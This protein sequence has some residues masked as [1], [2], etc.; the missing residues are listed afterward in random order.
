MFFQIF[1]DAFIDQC[2]NFPLHANKILHVFIENLQDMQ[3][4]DSQS[5]MSET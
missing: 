1:S 2:F 3:S 4:T 5:D